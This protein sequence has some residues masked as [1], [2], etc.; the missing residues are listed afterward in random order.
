MACR[1]LIAKIMIVLEWIPRKRAYEVRRDG[2]VVGMVR[3]GAG[4]PFRRVIE[5][6]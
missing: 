3:F 5:I 6:A 1:L 4:L 2:K